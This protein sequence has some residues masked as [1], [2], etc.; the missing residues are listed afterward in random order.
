MTPANDSPPRPRRADAARESAE[1]RRDLV[2]FALLALL[3]CLTLVLGGS[4]RDNDLPIMAMELLGVLLIGVALWRLSRSGMTR[5]KAVP[6]LLLGA[7]LSTPLI[8]LLPLPPEIW[9]ALPGRQSVV[10]TL[11]LAQIAP[12]WAQ[13]SLAPESTFRAFLWL[14]PPASVFL[15]TMSFDA[16]RRLWAVCV[17]LGLCIFSLLLAA[18]QLSSGDADAFRLYQNSHTSLP[19]GFFANRNHQ[20]VLLAAGLPLAAAF[21]AAWSRDSSGRGK[22]ATILYVGLVGLLGVGI[23]VTKSR[24]GVALAGLALIAS[25]II[26][27]LTVQG[28]A[29]RRE[30]TLAVSSAALVLI[31]GAQV[32]I[33]AVLSR[34]EDVTGREGRFDMWP[35][36]ID[37]GAGQQPWGAGI[38][39][40]E[41]LYRSAEPLS[42]LTPY[43][44]NH[45]HN[46]YL[47][48]WLEAGLL[49]PLILA[50][51]LIWLFRS[52]IQAWRAP[53][54]RPEILAR[55]GSVIVIVLLLH[56]IADYPLRMPS[57]VCLFAFAAALL[58]PPADARRQS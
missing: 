43:F 12:A 39:T 22:P 18:L 46:D 34:F 2:P 9:G 42:L 31:V 40:F 26:F 52:A 27:W 29:R 5:A 20:A 54:G 55:A 8:Q 56:S 19:V 38:G 33:G 21:V 17:V 16:R 4:G 58:T 23:L 25:F 11:E 35:T 51:F 41:A 36:V 15:M 3:L 49:F 57:L 48:L 14:L 30:I 24:A 50:G 1:P 47:E 28:R 6:L 13:I 53:A 32:A 37:A 7:V 45:A 10:E 44:V